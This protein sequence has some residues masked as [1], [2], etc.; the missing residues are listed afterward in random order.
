MTE[1]QILREITR[2]AHVFGVS[3]LT[4]PGNFVMSDG[5]QVSGYFYPGDDQPIIAVAWGH[6]RRLGTLL[7]EYSH[8]TQW[9]EGM[10]L[11]R[12]SEHDN[13]A[14]WLAGERVRGI[15]KQIESSREIEADCERRTVRLIREID[16]PIDLETYCRAANSYVHFYNV[17]A[18]I[19]KWYQPDRRPY[20]VPEV[21]A[22][23]NP[24]LD[25]DYS[26]TPKQLR[27]LLLT[28]V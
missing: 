6:P 1:D 22:E 5:L 7:H 25:A 27:D 20:M 24:T 12:Q 8:L 9:A 28:C 18:D 13:W 11:W 23:A 26:K 16:A 21:M 14:G 4:S 17:M 19:R 2:R 15:R 3:V 10:P